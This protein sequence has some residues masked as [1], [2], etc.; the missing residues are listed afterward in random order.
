MIVQYLIRYYYARGFDFRESP[1]YG[2]IEKYMYQ[3][4]TT[5]PHMPGLEGVGI[6]IDWCI[7]L[8][9]TKLHEQLYVHDGI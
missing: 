2:A 9:I 4:P 3:I 8:R 7:M 5:A 6:T 1:R